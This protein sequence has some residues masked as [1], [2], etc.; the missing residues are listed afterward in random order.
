MKK[1][2]KGSRFKTIIVKCLNWKC[3][4]DI[5]SEIFDDI[6]MEAATRIIEKNIDTPNFSVAIVMECYEKKDEKNIKKHYVYNTFFVLI[7]AGL[8]EKAKMLKL[9]FFKE[10]G[11]DLEKQ[12]LK[13]LSD[14][15]SRKHNKS[16]DKSNN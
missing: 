16:G 6:Y 5:D 4:I 1:S 13:A 12:G 8:Y 15:I 9:N 2:V 11:V 10:Y 3:A 14:G 7:N